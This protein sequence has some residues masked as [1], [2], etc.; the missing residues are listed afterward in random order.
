MNVKYFCHAGFR[1]AAQKHEKIIIGENFLRPKKL[2]L[3]HS[4]KMQIKKDSSK[5]IF[6]SQG[7]EN[8][9]HSAF[10]KSESLLRKALSLDGKQSDS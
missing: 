7:L 3:V 5:L 4:I 9:F 1:V 8:F 6:N 2:F 10:E